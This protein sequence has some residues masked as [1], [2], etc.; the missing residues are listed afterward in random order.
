MFG[1]ADRSFKTLRVALI[2][3]PNWI[4]TTLLPLIESTCR[5]GRTVHVDQW[6]VYHGMNRSVRFSQKQNHSG[7]FINTHD[8][9]HTQTI[10]SL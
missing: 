7:N 10:A 1:L 5:C 6:K 3:I 9:T 8:G 4:S 2:L